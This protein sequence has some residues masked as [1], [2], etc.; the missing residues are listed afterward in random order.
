[1]GYFISNI[2]FIDKNNITKQQIEYY[3]RDRI[4]ELFNDKNILNLIL[5]IEPKFNYE[6]LDLPEKLYHIS[7]KKY[8]HKILKN[9]LVPSHKNN[10]MYYPDR[11]FLFID[12]SVISKYINI[13]YNHLPRKQKEQIVE[14]DIYEL[15]TK[16]LEKLTFYIDPQTLEG[17]YTLENINP[18]YLE[19]IDT[20]EK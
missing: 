18:K 20:I 11:T 3:K 2:Q 8:R 9:G 6:F 5:I 10:L 13:F 1:M 7:Y 4:V 17:I 14:F 15:Q 12:K 16:Y 19:L